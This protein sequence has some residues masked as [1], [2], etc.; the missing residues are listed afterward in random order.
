MPNIQSVVHQPQRTKVVTVA[1]IFLRGVIYIGVKVHSYR[2]EQTKI[3]KS[4]QGIV[5]PDAEPGGSEA[6]AW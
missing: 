4:R 5:L 1:N 3:R 6:W 2:T